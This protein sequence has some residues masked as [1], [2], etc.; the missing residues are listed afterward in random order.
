MAERGFRGDG[1]APVMTDEVRIATAARYILL[2]EELTQ[3]PFEAPELTAA[4]RV[5]SILRD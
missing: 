2:A 4:E 5:A 1:E 3:R